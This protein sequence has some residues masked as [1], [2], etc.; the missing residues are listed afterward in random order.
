[1][2]IKYAF[3]TLAIAIMLACGACIAAPA[4]EGSGGGA[5]EQTGEAEQPLIDPE[6]C[7]DTPGGGHSCK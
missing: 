3:S 1:M 2:T 7:H 4:P 5:V 6:C